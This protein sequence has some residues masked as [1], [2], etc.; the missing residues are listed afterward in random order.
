MIDRIERE[1][2]PTKEILRRSRLH[3]EPIVMARLFEPEYWEGWEIG[4]RRVE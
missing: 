1:I 2:K 3:L 4:P